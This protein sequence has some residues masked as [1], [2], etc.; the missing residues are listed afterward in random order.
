MFPK[1]VYTANWLLVFR[2]MIPL[3]MVTSLSQFITYL[4]ILIVNEKESKIKEG[5]KMMG[6]RDSVFW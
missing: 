5:M 3:Y 1:D 2:V 4:L 6:L